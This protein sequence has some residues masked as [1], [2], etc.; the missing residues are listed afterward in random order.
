MKLASH[1]LLGIIAL[2]PGL[3][4]A[5]TVY[6]AGQV[7]GPGEPPPAVQPATVVPAELPPG[8]PA[9]PP[10]P[11]VQVQVQAGVVAVTP[12]PPPQPAGQW[13]YTQQYG[14]LWMPYGTQYTYEGST[15]VQPYSYVY[16]P[17]YGW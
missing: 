9:A 12:N 7:P 17:S 14:W 11:P 3:A 8:P 6:S 4:R 16:Y 10:S 2:T 1:I 13:V 15:T 5:Q